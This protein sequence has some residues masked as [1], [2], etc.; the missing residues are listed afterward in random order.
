[1]EQKYAENLHTDPNWDESI[2]E[3]S[4]VHELTQADEV[5]SSD[6]SAA[7]SVSEHDAAISD[8]DMINLSDSTD[9]LAS[10]PLP[11]GLVIPEDS[12]SF[13]KWMLDHTVPFLDLA[14]LPA[15]DTVDRLRGQKEQQIRDKIQ[16][17]N[18]TLVLLA[19]YGS[20]TDNQSLVD[21][22]TEYAQ[23]MQTIIKRLCL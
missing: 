4:P 16:F 23:K 19:N 13:V 18:S 15:L 7:S 12:G 1:M 5:N 2:P 17:A 6:N 10:Q 8:H 11:S 14:D 20:D 3:E 9:V 21:A 22:C